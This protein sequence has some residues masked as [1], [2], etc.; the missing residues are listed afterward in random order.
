MLSLIKPADLKSLVLSVDLPGGR[1]RQA[2]LRGFPVS[3]G[4]HPECVPLLGQMRP[5]CRMDERMDGQE[6]GGWEFLIWCPFPSYFCGGD[7][8]PFCDSDLPKV[9][10]ETAQGLEP[11]PVTTFPHAS[12]S[13]RILIELVAQ[14]RLRSKKAS[15]VGVGNAV[16]PRVVTWGRVQ[17]P[18]LAF[19]TWPSWAG[20]SQG[21][22]CGR[23]CA[24]LPL[25]SASWACG[26]RQWYFSF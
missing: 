8:V 1:W 20:G 3:C 14:D 2:A 4:E 5:L 25:T 15:K 12:S 26:C 19:L 17:A 21:G 6:S 9:K 13:W 16:R 24:G 10:V 7:R 11:C 22:L 18:N 23:G